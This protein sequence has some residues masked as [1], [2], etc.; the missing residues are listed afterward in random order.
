MQD[1]VQ[2]E[3]ASVAALHQALQCQQS[4]A[5][6]CSGSWKTVTALRKAQQQ[7]GWSGL[8]NMCSGRQTRKC[9]PL[10]PTDQSTPSCADSRHACAVLCTRMPTVYTHSH[11][12]V[13]IMHT[14]QPLCKRPCCHACTCVVYACVYARVFVQVLIAMVTFVDRDRV[15][16]KSVQGLPGLKQVERRKSLCAW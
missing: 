9:C 13:C 3:C 11:S 6:N 12:L 15:W 16:I 4:A 7:R 14:H 8:G 5:P 2:R 1:A 10:P